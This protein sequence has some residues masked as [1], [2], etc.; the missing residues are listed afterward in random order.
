MYTRAFASL[1]LAA[2]LLFVVALWMVPPRPAAA[3]RSPGP[4]FRVLI[5]SAT[6]GYRHA[7][8]PD[9]IA[10]IQGLGQR[11]R[12]AVEATED[13]TQFTPANLAR[14]QCVVFLSTT[15]DVLDAAQQSAFEGYIAGGGGYVGI[16]AAAD[17]EYDWPFY[18]QLVGAWFSN[19]P[20]PQTAQIVIEDA[21]HPA[22]QPLP[23]PWVRYEEWYNFQTNPRPN[24]RVLARLNEAT[25]SGGTMGDHPIV[26]CHENLG[27]RAWYTAGG[28]FSEAYSE[29]RF[30]RHVLGG[31]EWAARAAYIHYDQNN[32]PPSPRPETLS[33]DPNG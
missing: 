13:P 28:H 6:E 30:V 2:L 26:W 21:S 19:H 25:Y 18:G 14:F 17:C 8:I 3:Q 10:M 22:T 12:F 31:I 23:N 29:P 33:L 32:P 15:G 20:L 24:V 5:F 11:Y 7:S 27:G 16:H 4:R 9:G 1:S